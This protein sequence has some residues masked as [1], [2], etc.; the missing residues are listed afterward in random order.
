VIGISVITASLIILLS[1]F[2]GIESMITKLYS[3]FDSDLLVRYEYGKTFRE[4][5]LPINKIRS[6][7]GIS[8]ISKAV[9]ETVVVKHKNKWV[10]AQLIGVENQFLW[11]SKMNNHLIDGKA[12]LESNGKFTAM[13][14]AS[15]LD[16]LEG[17][18]HDINGNEQVQL[19]VP[20]RSAKVQ[21]N[22]SPFNSERIE[23]TGRFNFNKEVNDGVIL[24]PLEKAKQLLEYDTEL[25][26]V[27]IDVSENYNN[28]SVRDELKQL[29]GSSF[30]VKTNFEKNELIYKTSQSEKIIVL[31]ILLFI[32]ILAAFNLVASL[33]M[34]FVEKKDD[35]LTMISFGANKKLVFNVFF[36]EG[37]MIAGK[38]ILWGMLLGYL[39]CVFQLITGALVM[40]NSNGESFP[41]A[42]TFFDG[43]L[44]FSLV[45]L[46]SVIFSYFPVRYLVNKNL[47]QL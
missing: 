38:G 41:I 25:T 6:T 12:R 34:L 39:S 40:P 14:G 17:Q 37:L 5:Q 20:R 19:Y 46:L 23:I 32:F 47:S 33:T 28:E 31:V 26:A 22:S 43:I 16:K 4:E 18:I 9:E 15:L 21:L 27:Y 35:M 8:S 36:F 29:L 3:D 10:N 24:L 11:M 13:I 30:S 2:N 1:A 44:I 45:S 42:I 7:P